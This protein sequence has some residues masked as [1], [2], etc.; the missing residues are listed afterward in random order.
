M[1]KTRLI[2]W[3]HPENSKISWI[4]V[5]KTLNHMQLNH[6]SIYE[7]SVR[8][9]SMGT[10]ARSSHTIHIHECIQ[11]EQMQGHLP[12]CIG[13]PFTVRNLCVVLLSCEMNI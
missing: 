9:K 11:K 8:H 2:V 10:S 1:N 5:C 7:G 6:E 3:V 4:Q 12:E 13:K